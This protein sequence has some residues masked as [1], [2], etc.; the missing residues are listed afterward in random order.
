M[1]SQVECE[2]EHASEVPKHTVFIYFSSVKRNLM[3]KDFGTIHTAMK[4]Y[5]RHTARGVIIQDGKVLVFERWRRDKD[6]KPLHY[7][8]IPGGGIEH[9]ETPEQALV[10]EMKEEM[11]VDVA[12]DR[13]LVR[14][15]TPDRY[16]YYFLCHIT[17]GTPSFNPASEEAISARY[18]SNQYRVRWLPLTAVTKEL[19][20]PEHVQ[21]LNHIIKVY[22]DG[23]A[24][25]IDIVYEK[26]YTG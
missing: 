19:R 24:L 20:H 14:Q 25:P 7:F 8:S 5:R 26:S 1:S 21:A 12:I 17:S 23:A 18:Q 22:R 4:D 3:K 16:H 6:G 13:L 10:R 15:T 9:H 11:T 2:E